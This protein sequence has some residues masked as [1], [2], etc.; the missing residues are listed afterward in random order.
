MNGSLPWGLFGPPLGLEARVGAGALFG[1]L[2]EVQ[3]W[4]LLSAVFVHFSVLH[5]G[6]NMFA[7]QSLGRAMEEKF[8][9]ARL[10]VAFVITGVLGFVAS[11]IW[12]GPIGPSTAGASGAIFGLIG[13]EVG[14]LVSRKD[15]G[16]KDVFIQNLIM[17][18]AI[19]FV[20][21]VN[22]PAH[23]G[24][25]VAGFP[26][27]FLLDREFRGKSR[28]DL[29]YQW[30]A[31]LFALLSLASIALSLLTLYALRSS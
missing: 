9:G 13:I 28:F 23:L 7:L 29:V 22:N 11:R 24:G 12:Y 25:F 21:P 20:M 1:R 4:R 2:A 30:G 14:Y 15:P 6:M 27:G 26:L 18:V 3:P 8:G 31:V 17:A 19:A 5:L 16:A 10:I